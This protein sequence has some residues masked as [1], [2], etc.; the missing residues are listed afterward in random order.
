MDSYDSVGYIDR[1]AS[2]VETVGGDGA[3]LCDKRTEVVD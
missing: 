2:L 1:G 3:K